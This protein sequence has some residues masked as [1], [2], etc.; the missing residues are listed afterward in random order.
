MGEANCTDNSAAREST[1]VF[2]N[3]GQVLR[4]E[5]HG[6]TERAMAITMCGFG[7]IAAISAGVTI[8][9]L[10]G[11]AGTKGYLRNGR[12][13]YPALGEKK[14]KLARPRPLG[15]LRQTSRG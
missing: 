4:N 10:F 3:L 8:Q 14:R 5:E 12:P 2:T 15:R 6:K 13:T 9:R 7:A 11:A 1:G